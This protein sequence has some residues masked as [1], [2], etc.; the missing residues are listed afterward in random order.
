MSGRKDFGY[1][2][3]GYEAADFGGPKPAAPDQAEMVDGGDDLG[4]KPR[5]AWIP[6]GMLISDEEYQRTTASLSSRALIKKIAENFK[7]RRYQPIT[8][9]KMSNSIYEI[10]DGQHRAA[11]ARLRPDIKE[12]PCYVVDAEEVEHRADSFVSVNRDRVVIG[13][14]QLFKAQLVA[15]DPES[16]AVQA[17]CEM[18][19]VEILPYPIQNKDLKPG[20]LLSVGAVRA[21]YTNNGERI[22]RIVLDTMARA[23]KGRS[24]QLKASIIKGVACMVVTYEGQIDVEHLRLV[25]RGYPDIKELETA[26]RAVRELMGGTTTD[27]IHAALLKTYNKSTRGKPVTALEPPA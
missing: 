24:G 19:G 7:W 11:A 5:V 1:T 27:A 23:F 9:T 15:K 17:I 6:L 21:I 20:Q 10:I 12:L 2:G 13:P 8:V 26:A 3:A 22:L 16:V 25:L 18:V 14:L 4:P